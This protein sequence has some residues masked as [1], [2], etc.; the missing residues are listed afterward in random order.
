MEYIDKLRAKM[1]IPYKYADQCRFMLELLNKARIDTTM[2]IAKLAKVGI[3]V[4]IVDGIA[5]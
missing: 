4:V 3:N 5:F 1:P 2:H